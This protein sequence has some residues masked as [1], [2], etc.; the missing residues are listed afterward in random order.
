MSDNEI[1]VN[2]FSNTFKNLGIPK[3]DPNNPVSDN[4]YNP[5]LKAILKVH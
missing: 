5:A 2:F 3:F 1:T 4:V